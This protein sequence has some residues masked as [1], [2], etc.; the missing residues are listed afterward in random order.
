M[1]AAAVY[2]LPPVIVSRPIYRRVRVLDTQD[3]PEGNFWVHIKLNVPPKI[4]YMKHATTIDHDDRG[5]PDMSGDCLQ[6]V[7]LCC[8]QWIRRYSL[9]KYITYLVASYVTILKIQLVATTSDS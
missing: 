6:L 1:C 5:T 7:L 3:L 4:Y 8:V 9:L 2:T